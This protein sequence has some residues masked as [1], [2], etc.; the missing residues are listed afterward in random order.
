ML[1]H[2]LERLKEHLVMYGGRL[3]DIAK[4][5]HPSDSGAIQPERLYGAT[6][7]WARAVHAFHLVQPLNLRDEVSFTPVEPVDTY[8]IQERIGADSVNYYVE[9]PEG[10]PIYLVSA[11]PEKVIVY[12]RGRSRM[13]LPGPDGSIHMPPAGNSKLPP[14]TFIRFQNSHYMEAFYIHMDEVAV[15]LTM[16][17]ELKIN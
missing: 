17:G 5:R 6:R 4:R 9:L 10:E 7:A 12:N 1:S 14:D 3:I 15:N 16:G 2:E 11:V 8:Q 13:P